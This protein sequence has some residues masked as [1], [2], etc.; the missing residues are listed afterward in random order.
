MGGAKS[1]AR[2][3]TAAY[4]RS[5]ASQYLKAQKIT[6]TEGSTTAKTLYDAIK[7]ILGG[8][9]KGTVTNARYCDLQ[10]RL[11]IK[12]W[13]DLDFFDI[14]DHK[15]PGSNEL[16][17]MTLKDS[18]NQNPKTDTRDSGRCEE[19]SAGIPAVAPLPAIGATFG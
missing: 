14:F 18:N 13:T 17:T 10:S 1:T 7:V 2:E 12:T 19:T 15:N 6:V 5:G 3:Q 8:E 4:S 9:P 16:I 11:P